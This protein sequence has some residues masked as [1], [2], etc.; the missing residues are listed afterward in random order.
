MEESISQKIVRNTIFNIVGRFWGILVGLILIPYIIK[1]I[2]VDR[3]GIWVIVGVLTTYFGLLDFGIKTSFVKYIAEYYTKK[4]TEKINQVVSTGFVFYALLAVL[5]SFIGF[6]VID[7]ILR[8]FNIPLHL[9]QEARFVF[10]LGI[11][12]FVVSNAFS[13]FGAIQ[14]GLQ[15]MD[16]SNRIAIIL[17]LPSI[18]GTIFFLEMGYGLS[19]LIVNNA[20]ILILTIIVNVAIAHKIL[21]GLRF[22]PFLFSKK[23][24]RKLFLF[25]YKLQITVIGSWIQGQLDKILL[26]SFLNVGYVTYYAVASNLSA[27]IRE[28]PVLL[29]SAILPA[30]SELDAKSD[31]ALLNNLYFRSMKYTTLVI[32]PL[33]AVVILLAKPFIS[34]WL[35]GGFERSVLTLQILMV[36][37]FFNI[38][39]APGAFILNGLGKPQYAM[40]GAVIAVIINL[41]LSI[42]LVIKIGYFGVVIG[43]TTSLTV[44][45]IYFILKLHQVMN[46][47]LLELVQKILFKP[48]IACMIPLVIGYLVVIKRIGQMGWGT[49]IGTG[50]LYLVLTGL[51]IWTSNY[52]DDFD[53][54]LTN[55]YVLRR[56]L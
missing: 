9:Y 50:F 30:A 44:S 15:R 33:T 47:S 46:L 42:S 13:P 17:S 34:L 39:T 26:A 56:L 54:A 16:I 6:L 53:K 45:A 20:L 38:M 7:S 4:E 23:M 51:I 36:G 5:I 43:T 52:L 49:L 8:F 41:V 32:L 48:F 1:H 12:I 27:K 19:G 2:G 24:F 40:W 35:G 18:I 3:F 11:I 25:G 10:L 21:K 55:R 14:E 28:I 37:F 29:T 31:T 22:D